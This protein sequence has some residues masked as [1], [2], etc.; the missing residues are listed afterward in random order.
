MDTVQLEQLLLIAKEGTISRAAQKLHIPQPALSASLSR[1]ESELNIKLFDRPG[2]RVKLN[3]NGKQFLI[4]AEKIFILWKNAHLEISE[5]KKNAERK[6]TLGVSSFMATQNMV[7]EYKR[8]NPD[9][10][11]NQYNILVSEIP[12][13]L[14]TSDCDLII[15]T[16]PIQYDDINSIVLLTQDIGLIVSAKHHMAKKTSI[17]LIEAKDEPFVSMPLG[18]AYRETT[19]TLCRLAGFEPKIVMEYLHSQ[20]IDM[21][22]RNI[23]V[24]LGIYYPE[25]DIYYKTLV[26][27]IPISDPVCKRNVSLIW[28]KDAYHTDTVKDFISFAKSY[29]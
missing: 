21:V 13:Y 27:Y 8:R 14:F 29:F 10:R 7:Y 22:A 9:V 24:G 20:L 2:R 17:K 28:K 19:D 12:Y 3:T 11:I 6:I 23:G 5:H 15:S 18:Y 25:R 26:R 4:H 16:T 1:L